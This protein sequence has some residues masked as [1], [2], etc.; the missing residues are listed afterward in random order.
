M[1]SVKHIKLSSELIKKI[2]SYFP[3]RKFKSQAHLFYEG[4]IPISGYLILDGSIQVSYKKKFKKMLNAGYLL[5]IAELINKKPIKLSAE[6]FPNTEICFLDKT[7]LL[8]ILQGHD[9]ELVDLLKP[10]LE[11]NA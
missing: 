3:S 9:I 6:A 1:K 4:Q 10:L 5:G 7:T 8:E 2:T 11:T